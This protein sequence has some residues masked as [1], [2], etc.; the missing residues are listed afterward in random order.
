LLAVFTATLATLLVPVLFSLQATDYGNILLGSVRP[1]PVTGGSLVELLHFSQFHHVS[2]V[3][4]TNCLLP[5]TGG[6][7]SRPR[8]ATHTLEL[9]LPVIAVSLLK[10]FKNI[11][12]H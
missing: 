4:W 1:T 2:L 12:L 9:G 8:G 3:Q 6:S 10:K 11:V 7:S 5:A